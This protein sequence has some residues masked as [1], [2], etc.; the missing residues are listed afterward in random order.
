M[1]LTCVST[2]P[3]SLDLISTG[4]AQETVNVPTILQ[5][6]VVLPFLLLNQLR[7]LIKP[8][9]SSLATADKD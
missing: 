8:I 7:F 2:D 4:N 9:L 3:L 1:F 5:E 6:K